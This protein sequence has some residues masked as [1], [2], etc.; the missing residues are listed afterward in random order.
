MVFCFFQVI[1]CLFMFQGTYPLTSE[2]WI[3]CRFLQNANWTQ[4]NLDAIFHFKTILKFI[5]SFF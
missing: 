1:D 4:V 2:F 3:A 5:S